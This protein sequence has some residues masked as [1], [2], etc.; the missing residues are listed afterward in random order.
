MLINYLL[1]HDSQSLHLGS[2]DQAAEK[3]AKEEEERQS[4]KRRREEEVHRREKKEKDRLKEIEE[5]Q[6]MA[7][8]WMRDEDEVD[9]IEEQKENEE[10][11]RKK[12]LFCDCWSQ[13]RNSIVHSVDWS[14]GPSV[15][16]AVQKYNEKR[17][18]F[19]YCPCPP[20]RD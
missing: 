5:K 10:S 9:D 18:N 15:R 4:R 17:F 14:V 6:K 13:T 8:K 12:F 2:V 3:N 7:E 20:V 19:G 1:Q 11:Y 16:H